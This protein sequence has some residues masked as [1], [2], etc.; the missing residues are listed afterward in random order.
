MTN[1][2]YLRVV[3]FSF[4]SSGVSKFVDLCMMYFGGET[5]LLLAVGQ[6]DVPLAV[7][8]LCC[9]CRPCCPSVPMSK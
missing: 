6:I 3:C 8:P 1:T 7:R 4:I 5:Q 9:C 2:R